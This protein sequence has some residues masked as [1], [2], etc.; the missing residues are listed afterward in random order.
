M[1]VYRQGFFTRYL[2]VWA[3]EMG[4]GC[5]AFFRNEGGGHHPDRAARRLDDLGCG[6]QAESA[7]ASA[8]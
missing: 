8:I 2:G 7:S 3:V 5:G 6:S 1:S 4:S